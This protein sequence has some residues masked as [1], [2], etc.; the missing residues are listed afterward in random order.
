MKAGMRTGICG[1][2]LSSVR[3]P[4][5]TETLRKSVR[6]GSK[7]TEIYMPAPLWSSLLWLAGIPP[8]WGTRQHRQ[9]LRGSL[10]VPG[11]PP[12]PSLRLFQR[13]SPP[14]IT[15]WPLESAGLQGAL[16][17]PHS[18][19]CHCQS[20]SPC[21]GPPPPPTDPYMCKASG[22]GVSGFPSLRDS[23]HGGLPWA[24][25]WDAGRALLLCTTGTRLYSE[26][27]TT[28]IAPHI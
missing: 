1:H 26:T 12:T 25:P 3:V 24:A 15:L 13:C 4:E 8:P 23:E 27:L 18:A 20:R 11:R 19:G 14:G 9:A 28:M 2:Q 16:R 6:Q 17:R 10:W 7:H 5:L 21:L 22:T